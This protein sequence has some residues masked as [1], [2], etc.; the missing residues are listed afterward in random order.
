MC[1][2]GWGGHGSTSLG[3]IKS[4]LICNKESLSST[5]GSLG[6]RGRWWGLQEPVGGGCFL[7]WQENVLLFLQT[8]SLS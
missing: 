5:W 2:P 8:T 6:W 3:L 1:A 7:K 4:T